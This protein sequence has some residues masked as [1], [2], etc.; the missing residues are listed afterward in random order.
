MVKS[1][2]DKHI[3]VAYNDK[4]ECFIISKIK[5][6]PELEYNRLVNEQNKVKTEELVQEKEYK[7]SV[8]KEFQDLKVKIGSLENLLKHLF[9]YEELEEQEINEILGVLENEEE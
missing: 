7:D 3:A 4:G 6:V 8:E 9:G 5:T 1:I 2:K